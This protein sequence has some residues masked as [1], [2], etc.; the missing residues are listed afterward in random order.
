MESF[1]E[2]GDFSLFLRKAPEEDAPQGNKE[3]IGC[4]D[5]QGRVR[6]GIS[7][8]GVGHDDKEKVGK[9][10]REAQSKTDRG[11]FAVGSDAQGDGDESKGYTGEGGCEALV[12][13]DR[14]SKVFLAFDAGNVAQQFWQRIRAQAAAAEILFIELL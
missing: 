2:Q 8:K 4:P 12:K 1:P 14:R 10:D 5:K 7:A 9:G 11:L 13:F 3:D 6:V